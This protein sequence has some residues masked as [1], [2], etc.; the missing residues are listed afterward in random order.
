M[1]E[2]SRAGGV[3]IDEGQ[4]FVGCGRSSGCLYLEQRLAQLQKVVSGYAGPLPE[5]VKYPVA[6]L[7]FLPVLSCGCLAVGSGR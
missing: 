7:G 1:A 2:F 5:P 3:L 6:G 4:E